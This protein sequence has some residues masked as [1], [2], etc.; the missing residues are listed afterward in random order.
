[1]VFLTGLTMPCGYRLENMDVQ[2]TAAVTNKVPWNACRGYGKEAANLVM[3]RIMDLVAARLRMD[4][5][6]VRFRNFIPSDAFPYK[7]IPGLIF[8]S[9]DYHGVLKKAMSLSG[10]DELRSEQKRLR[11][12]GRYM[13]I[14]VGY[15]VTPEG[16]ALPGTMVAGYDTSTVKVDPTGMVTVLTGV[17]TPGGG[18]ETAIAQVVADELGVNFDRIRVVQGDTD[19]CPYGFGNYSGRGLV[20]GGGHE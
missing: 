8:D 4:P 9:G 14:G 10:Y 7:T 18:N 6:E 1:M 16:G 5:G 17:T 19:L 3:E 12:K 15:E 13:G 11:D 2:F 20:V